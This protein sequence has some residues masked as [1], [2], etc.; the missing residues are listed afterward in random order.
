MIGRMFSVTQCYISFEFQWLVTV[1]DLMWINS[2]VC[3]ELME[4]KWKFQFCSFIQ[5]LLLMDTGKSGRNR[6]MHI[7]FL[8][9]NYP[10]LMQNFFF[11][12]SISYFQC[13][14]HSLYVLNYFPSQQVIHSVYLRQ[15]KNERT[16]SHKQSRHF[17]VHKSYLD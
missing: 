4:V 10:N 17:L 16:V 1:G 7:Y 12:S 8:L 9:L 6:P 2:L 11:C 13:C 14:V 3:S 15:Y 5:S